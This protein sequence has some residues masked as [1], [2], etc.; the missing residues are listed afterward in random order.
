MNAMSPASFMLSGAK[1][2]LDGQVLP[3]G[4]GPP[5]MAAVVALPSD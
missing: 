2:R 4:E 3:S 5:A 1:P